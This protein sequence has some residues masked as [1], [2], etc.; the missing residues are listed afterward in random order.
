MDLLTQLVTYFAEH[1]YIAVLLALLLCSIGAPLPE[2]ITLVAGG[3][4]AGLGYAN[5]HLMC[6]LAFVGVLAGDLT[7][8]A[9]GHHFGARLLRWRLVARLVTPARYAI[10]QQKFER[11]GN[12]LLFAARFLPGLRT[13][14]YITAG[15]THRVPAWRFALF[16]GAAAVISVPVW[17]YLGYFGANNHAWL[18][19]WMHRGQTGLWVIIGLLVT[20]L[21]VYWWLHRHHHA[22][23]DPPVS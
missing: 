1:G 19:T 16:D 20:G 23:P 3:V 12:R 9:L 6:A 21:A 8:F 13:P 14:I 11:Y 17:V 22:P 18:V 4:I 5:V 10:V 15:L 7:M 2:D